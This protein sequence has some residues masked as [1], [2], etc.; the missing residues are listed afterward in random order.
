[1]INI[2][3][4][5][6]L[7]YGIVKRYLCD[8]KEDFAELP[9]VAE[10]STVSIITTGE[11]YKI[12]ANGEWVLDSTLGGSSGIP[13]EKGDKGDPGYSPV[14]GV[15]YWTD[16]DKAE[17]LESVLDSKPMKPIYDAENNFVFCNGVGVIVN[18]G[19]GENIITYYLDVNTTEE[20]HVPYG[21]EIYGGG[22]GEIQPINISASSIIVNGGEFKAIIGGGRGG[23]HVGSA[24]IVVNNG[25]FTDGIFGGGSNNKPTDDS[26][27]NIVGSV[28]IVINNCDARMIYGGGATGLCQVGNINIEIN[29]GKTS[30]LIPAGSNGYCGSAKLTVNG[31]THNLIQATGNGS[32]GSAILNINSGTINKM[33]AGGPANTLCGKVVLNIMGGSINKLALGSSND[34]TANHVSGKYIS[35]VIINEEIVSD[36]NLELTYTLEETI[37]RLIAVEQTVT[38][39]DI[40]I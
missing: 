11:T 32:I 23:S 31:G 30:Y 25:K 26:T 36:L 18:N 20:L 14:K 19:E 17:I 40:Q 35:G 34:G 15:D 16:A 8:T 4:S 38:V 24:S 21:C 1:M 39:T 29:D 9:V 22:N 13:G 7:D 5:G 6:D 27:G 2:I 3:S 12:N 33:Y 28:S 37:K 10:G